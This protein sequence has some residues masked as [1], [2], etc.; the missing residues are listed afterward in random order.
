MNIAEP[1]RAAPRVGMCDF[2]TIGERMRVAYL[3]LWLAGTGSDDQQTQTLGVADNLP[4]P[5]DPA[6][7]HDQQL[8][9]EVWQWLDQ[10]VD[11][12][13]TEYAWDVTASSTSAGTAIPTS[14]TTL[15][16]S[17][18]SAAVPDRPCRIGLHL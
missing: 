17:L 2:P 16:L 15:A 8:R 9:R 11:W 10:V 13:N 5:W 12:T 7:C 4:R 14:S 3:D 1:S 6:T 18:T